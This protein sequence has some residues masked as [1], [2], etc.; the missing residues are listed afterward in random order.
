MRSKTSLICHLLACGMI[1]GAVAAGAQDSFKPAQ[2]AGLRVGKDTIIVME[3]RLGKP[4][5]VFRDN[6]GA[7]WLY[8]SDVGPTPGK[9]EIIA[10]SK[11]GVIDSVV[12]RSF[13]ARVSA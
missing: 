7:T 8:Y 13:S 11:S 6:A 2:F 3:Q 4:N 1:L 5:K 12:P 9:V 10:E